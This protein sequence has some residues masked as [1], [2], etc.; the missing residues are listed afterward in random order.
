MAQATPVKK[1]EVT[2]LVQKAK[3]AQTDYQTFNQEQVDAIVD[4][5]AAALTEAAEKLARMANEETGL[6]NIE[7]KTAKNLFTSEVIYKSII[8][9]PTVGI[10]DRIEEKGI[11]EVADPMGVIAALIPTTNPTSTVIFKAL[12]AL[13]SRNAI[14]FSPH[15]AAVESII[16]TARL[17]EEAAVAAGAPHGLIQVIKE[18]T[19]DE[20]N[21][22]M[23]DDD[24]ALILAT[25]GSG[26]VKAA[27]SSGNPTIGVGPGNAPAFIE[28]SADIENAVETII[29][30]KTFDYGVICSSE[31]SIIVE[32]AVKEETVQILKEKGAYFLDEEEQEK[33]RQVLQNENGGLNS[34]VVGKSPAV[35]AELAEIEIPEDTKVLIAEQT[36]I[37]DDN[38]Y[39]SEKLTTL[40][41]LY[42][43]EDWEDGLDK[44]RQILNVKGIGHTAILHTTDQEK[45]E[46]FGIGINA[47]RIIINSGGTLGAIGSTTQLDPSMTLGCGTAGGGSTT[48]NVTVRH[49][50]N[51]RRVAMH[52]P[53]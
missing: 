3:V 38:I 34:Q 22:L 28:Q 10:I 2:G 12:L 35:L 1:L 51:V 41:T 45:I 27:Y 26:M 15:P 24:T 13:K 18:P 7:D 53:R 32:K 47:S 16:A 37:S 5:V 49:L 21:A 8:D 43:A 25:G 9:E 14:V 17:A 46:E 33:L 40:L 6:G 20:T 4:N 50:L 31:E 29:D 36:E 52:Q 30:S 39:A 42:T 19:L 44:Y 23:T 11:I 48:D